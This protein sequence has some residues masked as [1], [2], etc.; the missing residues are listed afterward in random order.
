MGVKAVEFL[1]EGKSN[2]VVIEEDGKYLPMDIVFALTTDR[3]YKNKLREGDLDKYNQEEI[4]T[5]EEICRK[6]TAEIERLYYV[7]NSTAM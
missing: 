6:R 4:Y 7:A 3:M 1:L 5:M 2:I